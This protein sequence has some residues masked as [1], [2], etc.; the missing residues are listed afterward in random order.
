MSDFK[1]QFALER[2]RLDASLARLRAAM[3]QLGFDASGARRK[4]LL[5]ELQRLRQ[6][7][8]SLNAEGKVH[9]ESLGLTPAALRLIEEETARLARTCGGDFTDDDL[10]NSKIGEIVAGMRASRFDKGGER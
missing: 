10:R 4:E 2:K 5:V 1:K 9:L 7:M 3:A 8:A 6:E